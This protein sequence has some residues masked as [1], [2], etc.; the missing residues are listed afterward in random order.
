MSEGE[1]SRGTVSQ[2]VSKS[3]YKAQ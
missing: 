3:I 2:Q 1:M